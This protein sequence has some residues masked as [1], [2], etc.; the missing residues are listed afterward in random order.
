VLLLSVIHGGI[1]GKSREADV[2][3]HINQHP[4]WPVDSKH[5][6][7]SRVARILIEVKDTYD[8]M[9][10]LRIANVRTCS[11]YVRSRFPASVSMQELKFAAL[12]SLPKPALIPE[13]LGGA[14][15]RA[16][17]LE[18]G[19]PSDQ[20]T[21]PRSASAQ[22]RYFRSTFPASCN[23]WTGSVFRPLPRAV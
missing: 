21:M 15:E 22:R 11:Y 12:C 3:I 10:D 18:F 9:K 4:G 8:S 17:I 1:V 7:T 14:I 2:N 16:E 23:R 6:S 19:E 13:Q 5:S 20:G